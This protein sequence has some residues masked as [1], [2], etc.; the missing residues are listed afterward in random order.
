[1]SG[2]RH[3]PPA[4]GCCGPP[5]ISSNSILPNNRSRHD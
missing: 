2:M 3:S 4:R 1:M 5:N